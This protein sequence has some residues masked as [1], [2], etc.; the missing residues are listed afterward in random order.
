MAALV[1]DP[2]SSPREQ[3][4]ER[5]LH[6]L[7][8][9]DDDSIRRV[10]SAML[11][12][13][14]HLVTLAASGEEALRIFPECRPDLVFMD[15][16]LGELDG[17]ETTRRI[18]HQSGDAFIPI[19]FMTGDNDAS[20]IECI[21]AGG[22]DFL[23]KPFSYP[24][25]VAKLHA[26]RRLIDMQAR[27]IEQRD[28]L[29]RHE[30][31]LLGERAVA[32]ALFGRIVGQTSCSNVDAHLSPAALF[33][34]D[35]VLVGHLPD[36]RQRV[37]V[38][39]FTGHGFSAAIGAL[40]VAEVFRAMCAKGLGATTL[41]AEIDAKLRD[42]LPTGL[43]LALALTELSPGGQ[44]EIWNLGLPDI[45]HYS[46]TRGLVDRV[47]SGGPP[48][49][50][51]ISLRSY[52]SASVNLSDSESLV[53]ATDG[54]LEARDKQ[55]SQFG[56][57]RLAA[58]LGRGLSSRDLGEHIL[59]TLASFRGG[60]RLYDD[61]TLVILRPIAVEN[62]DKSRIPTAGV[63][64]IALGPLEL[65]MPNPAQ[66]ILDALSPYQG[67]CSRYGDAVFVMGELLTNAIDYGLLL[68]PPGL[69]GTADTFGDYH[70]ER[71]RRLSHLIQGTIHVSIANC[72]TEDGGVLHLTV[73][74][75]GPGYAV[76]EQ[77][78]R[79]ESN[80]TPSRRGLAMVR[81]LPDELTHSPQ[82]SRV[83]ATFHWQYQACPESTRARNPNDQHT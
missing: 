51:R 80:E 39:D 15:V 26:M 1:V 37:L 2:D 35:I 50:V 33:N 34:G 13:D 53:L 60:T 49:G 57:E 22:D 79:L 11:Q 25:L 72:P 10:M 41:L 28:A 46:P 62:H 38:G 67:I 23:N 19:L 70:S 18:R 40:P 31:H 16:N 59:S 9:D 32:A 4:R 8:V 45:L 17:L 5:P 81:Q 71:M 64:R 27:L 61:T 82:G 36:G 78:V 21:E 58:T 69:K 54:I 6:I 47:S 63:Q 7:V 56:D 14:R 43:F 42:L 44:V 68:L 73:E 52:Q 66:R 65:R 76:A 30:R 12:A 3:A 48:L 83:E 75:P 55:E 77:F 24:V 74:D 20:H 29:Q